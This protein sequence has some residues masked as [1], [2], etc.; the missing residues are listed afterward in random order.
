V[1]ISGAVQ[2]PSAR[3]EVVRGKRWYDEVS[4]GAIAMHP[5]F[6][7]S[8]RMSGQSYRFVVNNGGL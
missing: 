5:Q 4:A 7:V 2:H 8:E 3:I 1:S 6:D